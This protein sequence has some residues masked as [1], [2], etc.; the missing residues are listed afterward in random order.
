MPSTP[1]SRRAAGL[2]AGG[3]ALAALTGCTFTSNNVSCSSSGTCTVT[4]SGDGAEAEILG[5]TLSLGNVE[6]GRASLSV[7]GA[8]VSC[9]EGESVSAGSLQ[10]EC[11]SVTDESVELTASVN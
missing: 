2:L 7:A 5:T 11:T 4:L 6:N 1:M 3:V 10:L 8:S 9:A